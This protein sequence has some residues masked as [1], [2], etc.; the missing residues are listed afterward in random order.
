MKD[1]FDFQILKLTKKFYKEYDPKT[2]PEILLKSGRSYNCLLLQSHYGY[3][4][5]IPYRSEINHSCSFKF[6]NTERSKNH[7]PGL[8]YTKTIIITDLDYISNKQSTIDDDEYVET[9]K[10]ID[11][12]RN[13]IT[14][15]IDDYVNHIK[16]LKP[17]KKSCL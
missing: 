3:F 14:S 10:S 13:E 15:Y 2:Y 7:S 1:E 12:I 5:C 16:N 4:I 6:Q 9:I 8:D 17:M 11:L